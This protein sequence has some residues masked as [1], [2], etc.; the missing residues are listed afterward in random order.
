MKRLQSL[1]P[2]AG[3]GVACVIV[4]SAVLSPGGASS[5][6]PPAAI[7]AYYAQH[8]A[9]DI[10]ADYG[11]L[12]ATVLLLA[13]FCAAATRI[14]GRP[15]TLLVAAAGAAAVFELAATGIEMALAASVHQ[16]APATTTAA[17]YQVAS[18]LFLLSTL[19]IGSSVG[20]V[21]SAERRRWLRRLGQATAALLM[22]AGLSVA[23]PHGTLSAVLLP[24]WGLL[25]IWLAAG[26]IAALRSS[27]TP[28]PASDSAAPAVP[29]PTS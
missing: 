17:L 10:V 13:V 18:R 29:I 22:L 14:G 16:Q 24:A 9:A 1:T 26:S 6:D 3:L 27:R 7:A 20:L 12:I 25:I 8:G 5:A 28:S 23:Y 21:A 11:S 15:G 2:L 19:A 4:L